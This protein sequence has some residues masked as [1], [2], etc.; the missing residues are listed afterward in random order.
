MKYQDRYLE[1]LKAEGC[2]KIGKGAGLFSDYYEQYHKDMGL[3]SAVKAKDLRFDEICAAIAHLKTSRYLGMTD[4]SS[5]DIRSLWELTDG[6]YILVAET[7]RSNLKGFYLEDS[8]V[9]S[10]QDL[11]KAEYIADIRFRR[12]RLGVILLATMILIGIFSVILLVSAGYATRNS[13]FEVVQV[14]VASAEWSHSTGADHNIFARHYAVYVYLDG[15]KLPVERLS[16][17]SIEYQISGDPDFLTD[18]EYNIL[19]ALSVTGQPIDAFKYDGKIYLK[20]ES[21]DQDRTCLRIARGMT[22]PIAV[23]LLIFIGECIVFG[24]KFLMWR[25]VK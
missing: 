2:D 9:T 17:D 13:D 20:K 14:T 23:T 12:K 21:M 19:L 10:Q 18:E 3:R 8:G 15:E 7:L 6:E 11:D 22:Y 24:I 16:G 1:M 25:K 4:R 5:Y